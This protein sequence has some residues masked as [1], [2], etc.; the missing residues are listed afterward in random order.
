MEVVF[1]GFIPFSKI[2]LVLLLLFLVAFF[3]MMLSSIF[4][5]LRS[6]SIF[7]KNEVVFHLKN[8]EVVFL[9]SS[10]LV[11]IRLHTKNQLP[12]LPGSCL[13]CNHIVVWCGVVFL[14]II[15]PLQP[16]CFVLFCVVGCVVAIEYE[17]LRDFYC[18][19]LK[20]VS[21]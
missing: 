14:P 1:L 10:S 3:C 16:N 20:F 9:V 18:F 21:L 8:I 13:K 7:Q 2:I 15:I 11:R 17:M 5:I 12:R 6:S 4:K 19:A